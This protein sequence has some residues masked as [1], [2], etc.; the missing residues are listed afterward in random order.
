[1]DA[2]SRLT[3]A[4]L[5]AHPLEAVKQLEGWPAAD[6]AAVLAD[7]SDGDI[8]AALEHAAPHL[9]ADV[10]ALWPRD[11]TADILAV[12]PAPA[13]IGVLRQFTPEIQRELLTRLDTVV[14][15]GLRSNILYPEGTAGSLAD[16]RMLTLAPDISVSTALEWIKRNPQRATYYHYV[17]E[18]DGALAG[19][20]TTKQLLI[21]EPTQLVATI[22][23]DQL[24]T[25]PA[26]AAGEELL[27]HPQWRRYAILPVVDRDGALVGAL[28]YQTL[29]RVGDQSG[30]PA[31]GNVLSD[32]LIQVW[33]VYALVG[34]RIMTDMAHVVE[35]SMGEA[36]PPAPQEGR[37]EP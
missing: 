22:M 16:P 7:Y 8:A 2:E 27:Q 17:V 1:M 19:M 11:R 24:E 34:L 28:R 37:G 5:N 4:Y 9:A 29:Q 14:G 33:E 18:R 31:A 15:V 21:A 23:T 3:L 32:A 35:T 6:V 10:L 12:L 36:P 20:V 25:I 30:V 13:A 26:E